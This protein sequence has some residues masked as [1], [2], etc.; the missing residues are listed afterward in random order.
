MTA[1][2]LDQYGKPLER[3]EPAID[4]REVISAGVARR[5]LRG[6]YDAAESTSENRNYW[7]A[8]DAL[9]ADSANSLAVRKR[10]RERARYEYANN[11][12]VAGVTQ[13]VANYEVGAGPTLQVQSGSTSFNSL[14]ESRWRH[15]ADATR[16][17]EKLRTMVKAR[18]VDGEA[19]G[20]LV[21][22]PGLRDP[23]TLDLR[24]VECDHFTAPYLSGRAE[25]NYVDGIWLDDLGNPV[26]YDVL[27]Y[28]PG[29][30]FGMGMEYRTIP[31]AY[32]IHLFRMD[33]PEQHRGVTE[34]CAGLTIFPQLRRYTLAVLAAAET[35]AD[36]S[37]ML[38][39]DLPPDV[40]PVQP[41]GE[42]EWTRRMM[43]AAPMGWKAK[44]I[45]SEHPAP[46]LEMFKREVL[47]EAGR[48]HNMPY[49]LVGLNSSASNFSSSR[50]D[51]QPFFKAVGI[52][53]SQLERVVLAPLF[54]AWFA[55][56]RLR[57]SFVWSQDME[58]P[59]QFRWEGQPYFEPLVE[60]KADAERLRT[61]TITR[62]A[63]YARRGEDIEDEDAKAAA[64]LG[65]T[66]ED[67][68]TRVADAIFDRGQIGDGGAG[69]ALPQ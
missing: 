7:A 18:V 27:R 33:R 6:R 67:Y 55:E 23:V 1:V 20:L 59:F 4:L 28:H 57:Y 21:T 8:A 44:Q 63:I 32:V 13:T 56:A 46:S 12:Y 35:A 61:G 5:L 51:H 22:N 9:D 16:L 31:A 41:L 3:T 17:A 40:S 48:S 15:W 62:D 60:A 49:T 37:L 39:T 50:L 24:L 11:G 26:S 34:F 30:M 53:Q 47:G 45:A 42:I 38:E 19:F 68:R 66:V 43:M 10:L 36:I 65:L 52:S 14:V 25:P 2:I 69:N 29:A 64:S 54:A 58:P